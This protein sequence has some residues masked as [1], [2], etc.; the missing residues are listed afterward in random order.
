[1]HTSGVLDLGGGSTQVC[2]CVLSARVCVLCV[3]MDGVADGLVCVCVCVRCVC[4]MCVCV[5]VCARTE[6]VGQIVSDAV[7]TSGE[8]DW[9]GG[10]TQVYVGVCVRMSRILSLRARACVSVCV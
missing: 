4:C 8:L 2:V 9:G 6:V 10:S 3:W 1:M 7:H 5:C